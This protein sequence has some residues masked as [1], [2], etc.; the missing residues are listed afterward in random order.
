MPTISG[1]DLPSVGQGVIAQKIFDTEKAAAVEAGR[2][3]KLTKDAILL[4][5]KT[6]PVLAE[7]VG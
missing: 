3:Y 7:K 1:K 2:S 5:I 6:K 4:A